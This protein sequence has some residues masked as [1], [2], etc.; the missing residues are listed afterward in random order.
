[1]GP[2]FRVKFL[3]EIYCSRVLPHSSK[4]DTFETMCPSL[5]TWSCNRLRKPS[6][7]DHLAKR[8]RVINDHWN[9]TPLL[10]LE[11]PKSLIEVTTLDLEVLIQYVANLNSR[12]SVSAT[13]H[14]LI[15]SSKS[16]KGD[17]RT[18]FTHSY[19]PLLSKLPFTKHDNSTTEHYKSPYQE[20]LTQ[21]VFRC[22]VAEP[23]T[24]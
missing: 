24:P 19:L 22:I 7:I 17:P 3:L 8:Q 21:Y 4:V 13:C 1:M 5:M 20:V 6:P 9:P 15:A 18:N 11:P 16:V 12:P 2:Q 14:G 23:S 10:A